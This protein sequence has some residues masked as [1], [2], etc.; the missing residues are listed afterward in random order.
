MRACGFGALSGLGRQ[1]SPL[2]FSPGSASVAFSI[3]PPLLVVVLVYQQAPAGALGGGEGGHDT[4]RDSQASQ[5]CGQAGRGSGHQRGLGRGGWGLWLAFSVS[6]LDTG[7]FHGPKCQ[8]TLWKEGA[9]ELT[10][11]RPRLRAG[12]VMRN[13][14]DTQQVEWTAGGFN[15]ALGL[16]FPGQRQAGALGSLGAELAR[17]AQLC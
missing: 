5:H 7:H 17:W 6:P 1:A 15:R 16:A 13:R 14:Q 12:Q 3:P 8:V 4:G 10:P 9:R 2:G 11:A